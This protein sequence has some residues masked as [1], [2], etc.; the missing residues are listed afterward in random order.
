MA[1]SVFDKETNVEGGGGGGELEVVGV[2]SF[3][4]SKGWHRFNIW[5][6]LFYP[7]LLG[8]LIGAKSNTSQSVCCDR[9][10]YHRLSL[11]G[12]S[13]ISAAK[14]EFN[15]QGAAYFREFEYNEN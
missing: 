13:Y 7:V 14:L 10:R 6:L 15:G 4:H 11:H 12:V 9:R 8:E 2:F 3:W 5:C 1:A